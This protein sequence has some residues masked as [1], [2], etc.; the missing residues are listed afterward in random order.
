MD[1]AGAVAR[2]V[3][4]G[5]DVAQLVGRQ[6][7]PQ[8]RLLGG[9][10][11]AAADL[12]ALAV[13]GDEVPGPQ[14]EAVVALAGI[15]GGGAEVADVAG[16]AGGVVVVVAGRRTRT[17]LAGAPGRVVAVGELPGR[18]V[19]VNVVAQGEDGAGEAGG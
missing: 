10:G 1:E 18:A 14:V 11:A 16:R 13:E 3:P 7:S 17:I 19:G 15:T 4:V 8:P 5:E 9:A 2:V 12:G 6:V